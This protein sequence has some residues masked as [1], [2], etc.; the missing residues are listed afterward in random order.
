MKQLMVTKDKI[1][2]PGF[3]DPLD[4]VRSMM[5]TNLSMFVADLVPRCNVRDLLP[6]LQPCAIHWQSN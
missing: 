5:V 3:I 4:A 6:C 1:Q 2:L